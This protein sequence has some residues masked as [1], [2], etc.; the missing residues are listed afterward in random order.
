VAAKEFVGIDPSPVRG[1]MT[2]ISNLV[3]GK[4]G[5]AYEKS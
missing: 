3:L 2:E 1:R 5:Q 4:K